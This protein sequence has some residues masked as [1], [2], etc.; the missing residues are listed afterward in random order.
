MPSVRLCGGH[1]LRAKALRVAWSAEQE[2]GL[3]FLGVREHG[4][5]NKRTDILD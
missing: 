3:N 1:T 4:F 2:K 5:E